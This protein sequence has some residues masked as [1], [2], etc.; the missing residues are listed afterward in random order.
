MNDIYNTC[1]IL[2]FNDYIIGL[3]VNNNRGFPGFLI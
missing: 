2:A 3:Q 1:F